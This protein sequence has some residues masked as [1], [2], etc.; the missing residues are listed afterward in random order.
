MI[1]E[2]K[3]A[4]NSEIIITTVYNTS[5][6]PSPDDFIRALS[7]TWN[8]EATPGVL[9]LASKDENYIDIKVSP[10][11]QE[12][13]PEATVNEI[14]ATHVRPNLEDRNFEPAILS[15]TEALIAALN[16]PLWQSPIVRALPILLFFSGLPLLI[17]IP[18]LHYCSG[19]IAL[20][21]Q[22]EPVATSEVFETSHFLGL[23]HRIP[24]LYWLTAPASPMDSG[25]AGLKLHKEYQKQLIQSV[26]P[27]FV[28]FL[29]LLLVAIVCLQ[30]PATLLWG[31][32]LLVGG[33]FL[34]WGRL[35]YEM[36]C[37]NYK[38]QPLATLVK[39][40]VT[41]L[42]IMG[43]F[44]IIGAFT[45]CFG[46]VLFPL[47]AFCGFGTYAGLLNLMRRVPNAG[48]IR[49][50][51]C[52][53]TLEKLT[54]QELMPYLSKTEKAESRVRSKTY[55]GWRCPTC[56][57]NSKSGDI[58]LLMKYLNKPSMLRCKACEALT[59]IV[60]TRITRQPTMDST[61]IRLTTQ[62][63]YLCKEKKQTA[64]VIP[65]FQG[66]RQ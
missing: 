39:L 5:P 31:V 4:K 45:G 49:C 43:G 22:L 14:L 59:V 32:S 25:L 48:S 19:R 23:T 12:T 38:T 42:L 7:D 15:S 61:G 44:L 10:D 28:G 13:L 21:Q 26:K 57:P 56:G 66:K 33:S 20:S 55:E 1:S 17:M 16:P 18:V 64:T 30:L 8:I 40:L 50:A 46:L 2:L 51:N 62:R 6:S 60:E 54:S 27:L 47:V 41:V 58:H 24:L 29:G 36:W 9:L 53:R 37:L 3:A 35:G 11:L 52:D 63:C 65:S 34:L